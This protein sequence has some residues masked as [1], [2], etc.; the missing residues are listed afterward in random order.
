LALGASPV[1][2]RARSGAA[3]DGDLGATKAAR[4]PSSRSPSN[5]K[6]RG[7]FARFDRSAHQSDMDGHAIREILFSRNNFWTK[8][9]FGLTLDVQQGG[10][11]V[12]GRAISKFFDA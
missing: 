6:L 9:A 4:T 5:Q 11:F 10:E 3:N 2:F 1:V 8:A 7:R 12:R